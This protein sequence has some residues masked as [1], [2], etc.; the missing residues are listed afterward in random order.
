MINKQ[1][2]AFKAKDIPNFFDE[3]GHFGRVKEVKAEME[4]FKFV[5]LEYICTAC[6]Y[7]YFT[8]SLYIAPKRG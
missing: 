1:V 8:R 5:C 3:M 6:G 2:K 7:I 4:Y